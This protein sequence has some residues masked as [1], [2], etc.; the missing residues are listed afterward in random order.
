MAGL[1]YRGDLFFVSL[2]NGSALYKALLILFIRVQWCILNVPGTSVLEG[3]LY[4]PKLESC[5]EKATKYLCRG[6]RVR[7]SRRS[8]AVGHSQNKGPCSW[9]V[10]QLPFMTFTLVR[11]E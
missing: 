10:H 6:N 3:V 2:E 4:N 5:Q 9:A 11:T 7:V 8:H 1:A